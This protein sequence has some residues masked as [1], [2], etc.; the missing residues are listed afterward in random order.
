MGRALDAGGAA[1]GPCRIIDETRTWEE[2]P[3]PA[4]LPPYSILVARLG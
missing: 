3:L 2:A 1:A 4:S